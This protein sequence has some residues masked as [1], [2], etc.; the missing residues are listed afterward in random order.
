LRGASPIHRTAH[1]PRPQLPRARPCFDRMNWP[2]ISMAAAYHLLPRYRRT[3]WRPAVFSKWHLGYVMTNDLKVPP[4][5]RNIIP[6]AP[7]WLERKSESY[8]S[9]T[10]G[11]SLTRTLARRRAGDVVHLPDRR[12]LLSRGQPKNNSILNII[13]VCP[14]LYE[15]IPFR[16]LYRGGVSTLQDDPDASSKS[17]L[18]K[19][20]N[21][22]LARG[23]RARERHPQP[24]SLA[25]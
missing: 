13:P 3:Q 10:S 12:K 19:W 25:W 22:T 5:P 6:R 8:P 4:S 17:Q 21:Q 14:G 20:I 15:S 16:P 9:T 18:R 23:W 24:R 11:G 2:A 1:G 7:L